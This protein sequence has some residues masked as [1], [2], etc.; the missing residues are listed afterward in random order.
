MSWHRIVIN[1]PQV[2]NDPPPPGFVFV[3]VGDPV[4]T[5]ACKELSREK[6]AM[7]FIV[8]VGSILLSCSI[9]DNVQTLKEKNSKISEHVHRTGYH[10]REVIVDEA[11]EIIGETVISHPVIAPGTVEPIPELQEEI[12]KQADGAIRDLFPRIPNPDR[13][14]IIEHAFKKVII[15][16]STPRVLC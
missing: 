3:P 6:D 10:F 2:T 4:L 13:V 9:T 11:R 1:L 15:A 12:N 16:F 14:M 5:N 8:S 7:I